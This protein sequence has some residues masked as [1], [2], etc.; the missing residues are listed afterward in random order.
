M[1]EDSGETHVTLDQFQV[2][3]T[4]TGFQ[5]FYEGFILTRGGFLYVS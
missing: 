4:D 3:V 5:D 1:A 2:G